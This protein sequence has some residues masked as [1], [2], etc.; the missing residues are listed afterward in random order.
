MS[1]LATRLLAKE[2]KV[3]VWASPLI[4]G[5]RLSPFAWGGAVPAGTLARAVEGRQLVVVLEKPTHSLRTKMFSTPFAVLAP[6]FEAREAKATNSPAVEEVVTE[7]VPRLIAG[8]SLVA[9][10]AVV[11]SGVE[12]RVM[13]GMHPEAALKQ[14]SYI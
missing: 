4:A 2:M 10:P 9:L 13:P 1:S 11:P 14:V 12:T 6:R 7:V 8:Y 3:T 5:M